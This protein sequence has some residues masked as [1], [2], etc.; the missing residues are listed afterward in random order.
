M[1]VISFMFDP[2]EVLGVPVG[3]SLKDCKKAYR[4]LSAR[5]H[6]DSG[7]A[8]EKFLEVQKAWGMLKDGTYIA[9]PKL[10]GLTHVGLFQF[11]IYE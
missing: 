4:K 7:G 5:Y 2:Y 10:H 3:T 1:E 8:S 9:L 6:P 11:A